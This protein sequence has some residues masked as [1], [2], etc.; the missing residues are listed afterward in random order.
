MIQKFSR[1]A[2]G[3]L[4]LGL[5]TLSA[6]A[7]TL[8]HGFSSMYVFGDGLS[9]TTNNS[10]AASYPKNYYGKRRSNGRVWVEVLAQRQN[11]PVAMNWSYWDCN[12]ANLWTNTQKFAISP[13]DANNALFVV[14]CNNADLYDLTTAGS[15]DV[16]VWTI[17]IQNDLNYELQAITT[18]YNKGVR[19]IIMPNVVDLTKIPFFQQ[20]GFNN[21]FTALVHQECI[22]YNTAFSKM[23]DQARAACPGLTIYQPNFF[24]LLDD[25]L[26]NAANYGLTNMVQDGISIDAMD[27]YNATCTT[28]NGL[29]ANFV[30]WDSLDPS[31][32]FHAVIADFTQQTV[33]PVQ[34]A[35]VT[36]LSNGSNQLAIVN[37][38]MGLNGFIEGSTN[39]AAPNWTSLQSISSVAPAQ[40]YLVPAPAPVLGTKNSQVKPKDITPPGPGGTV[41]V[42]ALEFYRLNYPYAWN[43]P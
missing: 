38:P 13:S 37:V 5:V 3:V 16:N 11:I 40:S 35:R 32:R 22:A 17:N 30:Y 14:W 20:F 41:V 10:V 43:W 31:A 12:S 26:V 7:A 9:T 42:T 23:L 25:V 27:F 36:A 28:N 24:G 29:G 18:L 8:P 19:T 2:T 4:L 6:H 15:T 33:S 21:T 34:I 1:F 39:L